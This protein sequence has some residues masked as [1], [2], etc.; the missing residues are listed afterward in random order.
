MNRKSPTAH[1]DEIEILSKRYKSHGGKKNR[2]QQVKKIRR[3]FEFAKANHKTRSVYELGRKQ[4]ID[5]YR[6]NRDLSDK[7]LYAYWLALKQLYQ[8]MGRLEEPP[9]PHKKIDLPPK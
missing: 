1:F 4:I 7:T 5:F 2:R 9:K 6:H 3:V 8:F